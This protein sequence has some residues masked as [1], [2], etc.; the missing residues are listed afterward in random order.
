MTHHYH[1]AGELHAHF[2]VDQDIGSRQ[3]QEDFVHAQPLDAEASPCR[4]L[5]CVLADGMGGYAGGEIAS[6]VVVTSFTRVIKQQLRS[7]QP[8]YRSMLYA[9]QQADEA[10]RNRKASEPAELF[11]MGSTLCAAWIKDGKLSF[12]NVGDSLIFLLRNNQLYRLNHCHNHREDM[13]RQAISQGLDWRVVSQSDSVI[14]YGSRITSYMG[15]VG[16]SQVHCP[17]TPLQ[18]QRGDV[19]LLSS[20]GLLTLTNREIAETMRPYP[21][22]TVRQDVE[23]MLDLVLAKKARHQDNVS[24]ILVRID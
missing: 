19:I 20:D 22:S 8:A 21:G 7:G 15:G 9:A 14:R 2:A 16:I 10:L 23:R 11:S 13:Q 24:A 5:L 12:I 6:R 1:T 3:N 18:L 17:E 4:E